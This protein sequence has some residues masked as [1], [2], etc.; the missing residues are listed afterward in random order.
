MT[1][2]YLESAPPSMNTYL[3][4]VDPLKQQPKLK[5]K[6]TTKMPDGKDFNTNIKNDTL[7]KSNLSKKIFIQPVYNA[8]KSSP[9]WGGYSHS[10]VNV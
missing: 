1:T 8:E 9:K 7:S 3:E 2:K 6:D 10:V 4:Y 5:P